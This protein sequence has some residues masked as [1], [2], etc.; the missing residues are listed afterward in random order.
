MSDGRHRLPDAVVF[1]GF[2]HELSADV[3]RSQAEKKSFADI[4]PDLTP[5]VFLIL[6]EF[7]AE[8]GCNVGDRFR[9]VKNVD[10]PENNNTPDIQRPAAIP[11]V[12]FVKGTERYFIVLFQES[13]R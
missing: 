5:D 3:L 4:I 2:L 7:Q 10:L 11:A 8:F 1:S 13:S 6:C 9:I 12:P